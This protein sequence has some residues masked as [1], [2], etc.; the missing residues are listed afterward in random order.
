L[1]VA[2]VVF[3]ASAALP[4]ARGVVW[5]AAIVLSAGPFRIARSTEATAVHPLEEHHLIERMGALT[6]V[7][8]GEAFVKVA[9]VVSVGTIEDVDVLALAFQFILTFAIWLSYFE[10]IP[11][12]GLRRSRMYA[13][14]A[15]HLGLQLGI[16]GTAIGVS[17]FIRTDPFDPL[18]TS[19]VLAITG[20][21]A[22]VYLALALLSL[23]TRRVPVGPLLVLRL[24]TCVAVVVVGLTAWLLPSIDLVV[25]VAALTVVAVVHALLAVRLDA[26]TTV[27]DPA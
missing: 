27:A 21:L 19:E 16:A 10:D 6:I 11:H 1:A 20:S 18:A 12:A 15:L 2:A 4:V 9:I 14:I 17:Q 5:A 7:V 13:W 8:C 23:C 26:E 25:G 3:A 24:A 22:T